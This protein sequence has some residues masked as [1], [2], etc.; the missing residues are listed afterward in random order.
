MDVSETCSSH[1]L[2]SAYDPT[3]GEVRPS[4]L[5]RFPLSTFDDLLA[6]DDQLYS[7]C[8]SKSLQMPVLPQSQRPGPQRHTS[9]KTMCWSAW[10]LRQKKPLT[11]GVCVKSNVRLCAFWASMSASFGPISHRTTACRSLQ[12]QSCLVNPYSG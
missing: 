11:N 10:R 7:S 9:I 4:P 8:L 3:T 2:T 1:D 12:L 6:E 5:D